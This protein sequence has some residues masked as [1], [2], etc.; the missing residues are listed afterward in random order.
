MRAINL[1]RDVHK[2]M[3]QRSCTTGYKN[4][5]VTVFITLTFSVFVYVHVRL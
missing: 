5:I 4:I 3:W 1:S 2:A